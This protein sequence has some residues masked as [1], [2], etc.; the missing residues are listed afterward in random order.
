MPPT[1]SGLLRPELGER[2]PKMM[3]TVGYMPLECMLES[4][5]TSSSQDVWALAAM[6]LVICAAPGKVQTNMFS[7]AVRTDAAAGDRSFLFDA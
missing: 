4:V 5:P 6:T 2:R 1:P 7:H 3:G